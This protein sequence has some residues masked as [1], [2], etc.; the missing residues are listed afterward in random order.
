MS[1]REL[2]RNW[3]AFLFSPTSPV[4]LALY[5]IVY[6]LIVLAF[7]C[8]LAPDLYTWY[9]PEGVLAVPIPKEWPQEILLDPLLLL[10][11][12]NDSIAFAFSLTVASAICLTLGLF[13]RC[14]AAL[15]FITLLSFHQH[16]W[17]MMN[18]GDALMRLAALY[19]AFSNAGDALSLD[20]IIK[21][22]SS[23]VIP[24][25]EPPLK[26]QWVQRLFQ[27]QLALIYCQAFWS[28]LAGEMWIKGSALYYAL[29]LEDFQRVTT[30][31]IFRHIILLKLGTWLTLAVEFALFT[32]VWLKD[33]RYYVLAAG[34]VLHL[35][36]DTVMNLPL[37]QYL[38][39]SAFIPFI[40]PE[41]LTL[42][43]NKIKKLADGLLGPPTL[44]LFDGSS[45]RRRRLAETIC[46]LDAFGRLVITDYTAQPAASEW[47][48]LISEEASICK[49]AAI[50]E[51]AS[52]A[53]HSSSSSVQASNP[54]RKAATWHVLAS[55][56]WLSGIDAALFIAF[57]MALI[58][59]RAPKPAGLDQ[60][61]SA[62]PPPDGAG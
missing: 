17:L 35:M 39:I 1:F 61:S 49:Q 51:N 14:S 6:G 25:R 18:S 53:A 26:S 37:F 47:K 45:E 8:L 29:R 32:L 3:I 46:R 28:K 20:R 13:T 22:W 58:P 60:I 27:L 31:G 33:L 12:T 55:D 23:P 2:L 30:S 52:I 43:M 36:I 5:R 38:M 41:H 42:L 4:P 54:S 48:Q 16:N 34:V 40:Y 50:S 7:C 15:L 10:P 56:Q 11:Q 21:I 24:P 44:V 62:V 9:G 57:R 59:E 19:L